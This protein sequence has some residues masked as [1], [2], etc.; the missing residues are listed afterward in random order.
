MKAMFR[1]VQN[2]HKLEYMGVHSFQLLLIKPGC[3]L[4]SLI[5]FHPYCDGCHRTGLLSAMFF[6]FFNGYSLIIPE[7]SATFLKTIGDVN[8]ANM[9]T[10]EEIISWVGKHTIRSGGGRTYNFALWLLTKIGFPIEEYTKYLLEDERFTKFIQRF[11]QK[12]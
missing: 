8:N 5:V 1:Y 3:L 4:Y 9:P 6:L 7:D 10:E 11:K 12:V 2:D